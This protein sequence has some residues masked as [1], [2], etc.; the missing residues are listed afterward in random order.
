ME[1][2]WPRILPWLKFQ[3]HFSDCESPIQRLIECRILISD[4]VLFA[5]FRFRPNST[6]HRPDRFFSTEEQFNKLVGYQS[7]GAV[8]QIANSLCMVM[9]ETHSGELFARAETLLKGS[10]ADKFREKV[11]IFAFRLSNK[12]LKAYKREEW[13]NIATVISELGFMDSSVDLNSFGDVTVS[14]FTE[15]LFHQALHWT[16]EGSD[17]AAQITAWLLKLGQNAESVVSYYLGP[18]TPLEL[19]LKERC[20]T[21]LRILIDHG[22]DLK[23]TF[24]GGTRPRTALEVLMD[25]LA[26]AK[27]Q[28]RDEHRYNFRG[29]LETV[30]EM[31]ELLISAGVQVNPSPGLLCNLGEEWSLPSIHLACRHGDLDLIKLLVENGADIHQ[32]FRPSHGILSEITVITEAAGAVLCDR[33]RQQAQVGI[34]QY[35][36]GSIDWQ[37]PGTPV[38]ELVTADCFISAALARN[39]DVFRYLYDVAP[40]MSTFNTFGVSPLHAAC[41]ESQFDRDCRDRDCREDEKELMAELV[42]SLGGDANLAIDGSPPPIIVAAFHLGVSLIESLIDHGAVVATRWRRPHR[43]RRQKNALMTLFTAESHSIKNWHHLPR[44]PLAACMEAWLQSS[45]DIASCSLLLIKNGAPMEGGELYKAAKDMDVELLKC[46]LAAGGDPNSKYREGTALQLILNSAVERAVLSGE[47][48]RADKRDIFQAA[49]ILIRAGATVKQDDI[50]LAVRLHWPPLVGMLKDAAG[51]YAATEPS[52]LDLENLF[53][54]GCPEQLDEF[55]GHNDLRYQPSLLCSA[56]MAPYEHQRF[57]LVKSL[58]LKRKGSQQADRLEAT[59]ISLSALYADGELTRLL[60]EHLSV[61]GSPLAVVPVARRHSHSLVW[62]LEWRSWGDTD[63]IKLH[64]MRKYWH[65]HTDFCIASPLLI[66]VRLENE[67]SLSELLRHGLNPDQACLYQAVGGPRKLM[68][69]LVADPSRIQQRPHEFLGAPLQKAVEKNKVEIVRLLVKA[70]EDVKLFDREEK[71]S[72]SALQMAVG[73]A[74]LEIIEILLGAGADVNQ[75]AAPNRGATA[76]QLAAAKGHIGIAK[77]LIDAGAHVDAPGAEKGG[78]TALEAAAEHGR[79]DMAQ[80][81]LSC[82]AETDGS[83]QLQFIRAIQFATREG[84]AVTAKL[85]REWR[86][87]TELDEEMIQVD[88]PEEIETPPSSDADSV[89]TLDS[90]YEDSDTTSECLQD[91]LENM[92]RKFEDSEDDSEDSKDTD[93]D[94]TGNKTDRVKD[95]QTPRQEMG[96]MNTNWGVEEATD[97]SREVRFSRE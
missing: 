51:V 21:L 90:D 49:N 12:H 22:A 59:A 45:L 66:A 88:L 20:P 5:V 82:G 62:E 67:R 37:R 24:R 91:A 33:Q 81:L 9:P 58:L 75:E 38:E 83:G 30:N 23:R 94:S 13:D 42:L 92:D 6:I 41:C 80:L 65:H 43:G 47:L 86:D 97:S 55:C 73:E 69:M 79:I 63:N 34:L 1:F 10:A 25:A 77:R 72:Y 78:R 64:A 32:R 18:I 70:G 87:W 16:I 28:S 52:L 61:S 48:D 85:L 68:E 19:A 36:L 3:S 76:L 26:E 50:S 74:E 60:L 56:V 89:G 2:E 95:I 40:H 35:L 11:V 7:T 29:G 31:A 17:T 27:I 4:N 46:I 53:L 8:P 44:T 15:G 84:H 71:R 54:Q 57:R 96:G 39:M 93:E 14:A